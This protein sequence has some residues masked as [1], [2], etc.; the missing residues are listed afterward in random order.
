MTGEKDLYLLGQIESPARQDS[1]PE[2]IE[3][4]RREIAKGET[5]YTKDELLIL[6]RKLDE[7]EDSLRVLMNP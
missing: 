2:R 7:G 5:L 3:K 4:L 1:L 6:R